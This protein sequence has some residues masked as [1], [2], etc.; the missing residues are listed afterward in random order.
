VRGKAAV[1]IGT[2]ELSLLSIFTAFAVRCFLVALFLPFSALDKILNFKQA[3]GQAAQ[4]IPNRSLAIILTAG[5]FGIEVVMSLAI[6]TGIAD[7][8]AAGLVYFAFGAAVLTLIITRNITSTIAVIIVAGAC[9]VA[10]GKPL[11]S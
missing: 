9:G 7:R 11:A 6:L 10:A 5:G 3:A 4:A 8:L 1:C 2:G